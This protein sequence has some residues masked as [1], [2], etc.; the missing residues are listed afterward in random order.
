MLSKHS[1]NM[2]RSKVFI[3]RSAAF[4]DATLGEVTDMIQFHK[5]ALEQHQTAKT[6][7]KTT[8]L[9]TG[10]MRKDTIFALG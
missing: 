3:Y 1:A 10:R 5:T 8:T 6:T 4:S 7:A 9:T 2:A